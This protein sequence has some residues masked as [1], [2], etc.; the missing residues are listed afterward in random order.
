MNNAEKVVDLYDKNSWQAQG[1]ANSN[2]TKRDRARRRIYDAIEKCI[3]KT[4]TAQQFKKH[5]SIHHSLCLSVIPWVT[6]VWENDKVRLEIDRELREVCEQRAG[7]P[8][9]G[10]VSISAFLSHLGSEIKRRRKEAH[11]V[12]M[13][14]RWNPE[15][16]TTLWQA[17]LLDWIES[18]L[19]R[20]RHR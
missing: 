9:L 15:A 6:V 1:R 8:E 10:G 2:K 4:F 20:L 7:R 14:G 16:I 19:D 5:F 17:Q 13:N 3:G 18:E 12:K 11:D